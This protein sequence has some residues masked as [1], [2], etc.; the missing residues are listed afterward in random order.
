MILIIIC[1][2]SYVVAETWKRPELNVDAKRQLNPLPCSSVFYL[3][4]KDEGRVGDLEIRMDV[5]QSPVIL[6]LI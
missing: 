2:T 6:N 5:H 3:L 4:S 1:V